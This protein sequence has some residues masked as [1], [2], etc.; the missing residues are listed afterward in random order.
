MIRPGY[1]RF[2]ARFL[3]SVRALSSFPQLFLTEV[4]WGV[5]PRLFLYRT[6]TAQECASMCIWGSNTSINVNCSQ[7]VKIYYNLAQ[8][9]II[10]DPFLDLKK[11]R[12][13]LTAQGQVVA[14]YWC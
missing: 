10:S 4:K 2:F 12:Y 8:V 7:I 14:V 3:P 13:L 9:N 11:L 6:S 5:F 1:T